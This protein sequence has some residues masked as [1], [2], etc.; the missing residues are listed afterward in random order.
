MI[1]NGR[2]ILFRED[3]QMQAYPSL[4]AKEDKSNNTMHVSF[5]FFFFERDHARKLERD[6][7]Q[8]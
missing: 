8:N 3:V 6:K 4:K 1:I 7:L 2:R 5:F